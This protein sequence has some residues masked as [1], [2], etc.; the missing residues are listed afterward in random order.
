LQELQPSL[1]NTAKTSTKVRI[2]K[3]HPTSGLKNQQEIAPNAIHRTI[4]KL[5]KMSKDLEYFFAIV[6]ANWLQLSFAT[7][8]HAA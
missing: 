7:I 4:A 3:S 6:F 8:L 2:R 1:R 5:P